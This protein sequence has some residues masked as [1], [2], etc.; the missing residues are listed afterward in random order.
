MHEITISQSTNPLDRIG[1]GSCGSV[2][3]DS[4]LYPDIDQCI[5]SAIVLKRADGLPD[6]S[7]EN[8][9]KMHKHILSNIGPFRINI[10]QHIAFLQPGSPNWSHILPRLPSDSKP[11]QALIS[12]RILPMPRDTRRLIVQKFWNGPANMIDDIVDDRRNQHCLIRPYLG[13]RRG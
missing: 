9:A 4:S 6:R 8:E 13:R 10:P 3:A 5:I 7:I 12:E 11:C 1:Y 2:W